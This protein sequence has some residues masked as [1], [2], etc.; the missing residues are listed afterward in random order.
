MRLALL[1]PVLLVLVGCSVGMAVSGKPDP[2]LGAIGPGKTR[3]EV[4]L[5]LGPPARSSLQTDGTRAD[6]YEYEIGNEP[7]AGRAV[8]HAIM[9]VLT[10]GIWEIVGTPIEAF[11]G[12]RYELT[13]IYSPDDKVSTFSSRKIG[14]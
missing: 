13:V 4:E 14:S 8:G 11:Q 2:N 1:I 5:H 10:L 3:A 12:E 9:D 6:I 7:S